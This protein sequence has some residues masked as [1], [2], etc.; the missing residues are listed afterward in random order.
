MPMT[1]R[2]HIIRKNSGF[3]FLE[4]L[5]ALAIFTVVS[6]GAS[7]ILSSFSRDRDVQKE[8]QQRLDELDSAFL[9]IKQDL[10]QLI[11]RGVRV[12]GKVSEQALFTGQ[13]LDSEDQ[14]L[15]FVRAGWLNPDNLLPRSELQRVYYRLN[16]GVFER[17]YDR[18]LDVPAGTQPQYMALISRVTSLKFR[19][20]YAGKW[21]DRLK[22]K[23]WPDG[24]AVVVGLEDKGEIERRFVVP[25]QWESSHG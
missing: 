15:T 20:Y 14:G 6:L 12:D 19:F 13:I 11:S 8:H 3:T 2:E 17:G 23:S 18:V 21:Q 5:L 16:S 10:R 1:K 4:M 24:I 25:S 9:I 22:D 7:Q